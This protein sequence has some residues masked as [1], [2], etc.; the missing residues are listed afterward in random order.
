MAN[1]N[2]PVSPIFVAE[3][4]D[5]AARAGLDGHRIAACIAPPEQMTLAQFGRLWFD[6]AAEME[7]EML[8]VAAH[9]MRPGSFALLCHALLS[10]ET[11]GDALHRAID[12][13]AVFLGSP[14]GELTIRNGQAHIT[15]RDR[16]VPGTAFGYRILLIVLLGPVFWLAR[17][18]IP[19]LGVEFACAAP[20]GADAYTHFFGTPVGFNAEMTRV[21]FDAGVLSSRVTR[22]AP[23]LRRFLAQ[24]PANLL[25]GYHGADDASGRIRTILAELPPD[26]WPDFETLARRFRMSPSSLRRQLGEQG[27]TYRALKAERRMQRARQLLRDTSVTVAEIA[28]QL[29]YAE[30]SA[31]Y[32]AFTAATGQSPA[33]FRAGERPFR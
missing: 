21:V 4:L 29:G 20:E 24:A 16:A 23:A 14:S 15:I 19:L 22:R 9:P 6:L 26:A 8:G 12:A 1:L 31:F 5:C 3:V 13:L 25:V 7:D 17:R 11:M 32:R 28:E 2:A 30:P 27:T 33:Q 18:R 10:A